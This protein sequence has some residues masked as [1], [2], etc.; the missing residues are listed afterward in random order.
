MIKWIKPVQPP[1]PVSN[2]HPTPQ[3]NR[4]LTIPRPLVQTPPQ[5]T[6]LPLPD[7]VFSDPPGGSNVGTGPIA[8]PTPAF[9]PIPIHI[10]AQFFTPERDVKPPYPPIKLASGEEATLKLRLT[11]DEVGRVVAVDPIGRADPIFLASARRHLLARWHYKPASEDGRA[12][13]STMVITLRFQ[14]D[15]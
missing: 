4:G 10:G 11:I 9:K 5:P 12:V 1:P 6:P 13:A 8:E 15:G 3:P 7:P 2:P 14:L